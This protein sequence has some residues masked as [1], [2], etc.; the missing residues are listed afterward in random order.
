MSCAKKNDFSS[1]SL[2]VELDSLHFCDFIYLLMLYITKKRSQGLRAFYTKNEIK[3]PSNNQQ[4]H[5]VSISSP[6]TYPFLASLALI[7]C[8]PT[9]SFPSLSLILLK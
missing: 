6:W 2:K 3:T 7:N 1:L 5:E 4:M 8:V 9:F